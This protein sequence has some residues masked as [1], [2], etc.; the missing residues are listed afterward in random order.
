MPSMKIG[1]YK[2]FFIIIGLFTFLFYPG[3]VFTQ[4]Y[5][6]GFNSH[7]V[8][9]DRRTSL[10]LFP[11]KAYC[12]HGDF[13]ISFEM[14]FLPGQKVYFG[15]ILRLIK[16]DKEN[17][18]LIYDEDASVRKHFKVVIGGN[19]TGIGFDLDSDN[20]FRK[21]NK[22]WLKFDSKNDRLLFYTGKTCYIQNKIG[23]TNKSCFKAY[24]GTNQYKQFKVTDVPPMRI[25]NIQINRDGTEQFHWP[26]DE[27]DG[28]VVHEIINNK[29][30]VVTNPI[31][32]KNEHYAWKLQKTMVVKGNASLA[33]NSGKGLLYIVGSDSLFTYSIADLQLTGLAY[34]SGRQLLLRGNQSLFVPFT[35]NLYNTY[36]DQKLVTAFNFNDKRWNK[37]YLPGP[38]TDYWQLNKFFSAV[39]TSLYLMGGYGHLLYK[40]TIYRYHFSSGT[41]QN[42]MPS[43][44]RLIP[45]YLA[46]LG[47]T[48]RGDSVYIL[49]GFGS[50]T[51]QQILNPQSIYDMMLFDVKNKRFRKL[52]DLSPGKEDFVFANSLVIDEKTKSYYGLIFPNYRYNSELQ[53]IKGSLFSPS[54]TLVGNKIPYS[55][56]DVHSFADLYYCPGNNTFV[57]VTLLSNSNDNNTINTTTVNIYTLAGPPV[58]SESE[59]AELPVKKQFPYLLLYSILALLI[60]VTGYLYVR[61]RNLRKAVTQHTIADTVTVLGNTHSQ[62][63]LQERASGTRDSLIKDEKILIA[64]TNN[65][66][67]NKGSYNSSKKENSDK[68]NPIP[69]RS[70][71]FLFGE[72]QIFD[73]DGTDI[74]GYFTPLIKELFLLILLYTLKKGRGV[75]PDKLNE[76]LWSDKSAQAARNNRS[77]NIAKL[78]SILDKVEH[79]QLSKDTGYWKL[80]I[81]Y[82]FITV[83]YH[84]YLSIVTD[85]KQLN[86]QKINDLANITQRGSFLSNI[87]YGWLDDFKSEV[88]NTIIDIY[89][90]FAAS[91]PIA[92]DPEFLVKL[93]NYIFYFDAVNEEAMVIKCKSL[94]YLGKHSLAKNTFDSFIKEYKLIYGEEFNKDLQSILES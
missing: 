59:Y 91:I 20:L 82:A 65:R 54:Y 45:R 53:L 27:R 43:G 64:N 34:Q 81:D 49:G 11:E 17:I 92:E 73:K 26:L 6:L 42:I 80:E 35:N 12:F 36:I 24:F 46:A 25:R 29:E 4:S 78:K 71:I 5:G 70:S 79:C 67:S 76:I 94:A 22:C 18:D 87:E 68:G 84:D 10:D 88:S 75:S 3:K 74:S 44:D 14:S 33:F 61:K 21:W 8:V 15:Y 32:I 77:V 28:T 85:K 69:T 30:A 57:A 60:I 90:H 51:G 41:W 39:D 1:N 89:L 37:K 2:I 55:F 58:T 9:Q 31:W 72:M 23:L 62:T 13:E 38:S 40:N 47:T 63:V 93:A 52:Y 83:D 56:H 66:N 7:D 16:D 86:K 48:A 19:L 50:P